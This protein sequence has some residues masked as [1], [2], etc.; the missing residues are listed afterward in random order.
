MPQIPASPH[1]PSEAF[2]SHLHRQNGGGSHP[3]LDQRLS[4]GKLCACSLVVDLPRSLPSFCRIV[5]LSVWTPPW[6]LLPP[7]PLLS[8]LRCHGSPLSQASQSQT[9]GTATDWAV[10]VVTGTLYLVWRE[11]VIVVNSANKAN[12]TAA[13]SLKWIRIHRKTSMIWSNFQGYAAA[14]LGCMIRRFLL[15]AADYCWAEDSCYSHW[16]ICLTSHNDTGMR[17]HAM[18]WEFLMG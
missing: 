15:M 14:Q 5:P 6:H 18:H 1:V 3:Q 7:R 4:A 16:T 10:R 9:R 12:S 11:I 8:R 13:R 17:R 2:A